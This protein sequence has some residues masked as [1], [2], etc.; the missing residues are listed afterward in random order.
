MPWC[1]ASASALGTLVF[2][3]GRPRI[4]VPAAPTSSLLISFCMNTSNRSTTLVIHSTNSL[5]CST[6]C[7]YEKREWIAMA[8]QRPSSTTR[9]EVYCERSFAKYTRPCQH[10]KKASQA[11]ENQRCGRFTLEMIEGLHEMEEREVCVLIGAPYRTI[12]CSTRKDLRDDLQ[13]E[14]PDCKDRK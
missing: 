3:G 2:Q 7:A 13:S 6:H 11:R 4:L 9:S 5:T 10:G 1:E 14:G 12:A 8:S